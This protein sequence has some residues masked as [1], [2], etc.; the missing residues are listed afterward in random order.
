MRICRPLTLIISAAW[1]CAAAGFAA[2][3]IA[4]HTGASGNWSSS[5][6]WEHTNPAAVGRYPNNGNSGLTYDAVINDS[7]GGTITLDLPIVIQKLLQN[8]STLAGANNLTI[9]ELYTWN[10]GRLSGTGQVNAN[11]GIAMNN[12]S[13]LALQ[14]TLNNNAT[15]HWGGGNTVLQIRNGGTFNNAGTFNANAAGSIQGDLTGAFINSGTF[16]SNA[17]DNAAVSFLNVPFRSTG[18]INV[19]SG[20]FQM[21]GGSLGG[22]INIAAGARFDLSGDRFD[23]GATRPNFAGAGTLV[24]DSAGTFFSTGLGGTPLAIRSDVWL[25]TGYWTSGDAITTGQVIWNGTRVEGAGTWTVGSTEPNGGTATL[26]VRSSVVLDRRSLAVER[27]AALIIDGIINF[28]NAAQITNRGT[29][30][31]GGLSG[32]LNSVDASATGFT[33][34]G[35][36]IVTSGNA[37]IG[38]GFGGRG[39]DVVNDGGT[40][41]IEQGARLEVAGADIRQN[42]G[43]TVVNGTLRPT[44]GGPVERFIVRGGDIKGRGELALDLSFVGENFAALAPGESVGKLAITGSLTLASNTHF[45]VELAGRTQVT[46]YDLLTVSTIAQLDGAL[47]VFLLNGFENTIGSADIFNVLTAGVVTGG[48]DN[49]GSGQRVTTADG[50]GSFDVFYG[51][52]SPYGE[53]NVALA[54][55]LPVP[56]PSTYALALLGSVAAAVLRKRQA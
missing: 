36:F 52:G 55:F 19:N 11:G 39:I 20:R 12:G 28:Y 56:E 8:G 33:N 2:D 13:A 24:I 23:F 10:S 37:S 25:P 7:S 9:N 46:Q 35:V 34:L 42:S 49:V 14:R 30:T 1:F 16:N 51:A 15:A 50:K 18:T 38:H 43:T 47:D 48:F 6:I 21:R 45:Q 44:Q 41:R 40:M 53:N 32:G 4:I 17:P 3:D 5:T 22:N 27:G 31:M 26:D 29:F 54:N